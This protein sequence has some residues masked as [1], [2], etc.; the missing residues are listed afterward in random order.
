M[1]S[2][3]R[4]FPARLVGAEVRGAF[5]EDV[6]LI[7][8][9][10]SPDKKVEVAVTHLS[11]I[12][13]PKKK[14]AQTTPI[15]MLHGSYQNR[16][17]WYSPSADGLAKR[18]V[19]AGFDVWLMEARGHGL[20]PLN[21]HFE[22]NTLGDYARYDLPAVNTF[23]AEQSGAK[24]VWL[25][26]SEGAGA[27]LL[28]LASGALSHERTAGVVGLGQVLPE[29]A[30]ARIPSAH[31]LPSLLTGPARHNLAVG[32]ELEPV[33]LCREVWKEASLLSHFGAAMGVNVRASLATTLMPVA[34][35][36]AFDQTS[37]SGLGDLSLYGSVLQVLPVELPLERLG[38]ESLNE[39]LC[40]A[41]ALD[42]V[43]TPLLR[44]LG[45]GLNGIL[46]PGKASS[47]A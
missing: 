12:A 11:S 43:T 8:P 2:S 40:D 19:V 37:V 29:Q 30:L 10:N 9:N 31:L 22:N 28:S 27:I 47:V 4:F 16:R 6:Y 38:R 36:T 17:F 32:P 35:L 23:V 24:P 46:P 5:A 7:K 15:I 34:W 21:D 3:S 41:Q 25:G 44:F 33:G 26:C 20:S 13:A 42:V 39:S 18:L 14:H 1:K 45:E